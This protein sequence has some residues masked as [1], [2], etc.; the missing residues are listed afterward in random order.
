MQQ[1]FH[2]HVTFL[3]M[4]CYVFEN[5]PVLNKQNQFTLY[6][7]LAIC[8]I[9]QCLRQLMLLL[10]GKACFR[11]FFRFLSYFF[12]PLHYMISNKKIRKRLSLFLPL[13]RLAV[14]ETPYCPFLVM[15][16]GNC[17]I[18]LSTIGIIFIIIPFWYRVCDLTSAR[19]PKSPCKDTQL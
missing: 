3:I 18:L 6:L 9:N 2:F 11:K 4:L 13:Q 10:A 19:A 12:S 8:V 1:I 5:R 17:A 14:S 16:T 15:I 7:S